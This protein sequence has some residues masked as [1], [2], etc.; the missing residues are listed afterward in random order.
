MGLESHSVRCRSRSWERIG[1]T[2]ATFALAV[3]VW[4]SFAAAARAAERF[5]SPVQIPT[6]L[7]SPS[8]VTLGDFQGTGQ[9]DIA[10][11]GSNAVS[12][13]QGEGGGAFAPP[14][15]TN[16]GNTLLGDIA[17]LPARPD[18]E[19]DYV[20]I[21][22]EENDAIDIGFLSATGFE[23]YQQLAIPCEPTEIAAGDFTGEAYGSDDFA[24]TCGGKEVVI[25]L[26]NPPTALQVARRDNNPT[27]VVSQTFVLPDPN[28][29]DGDIATTPVPD[30]GVEIIATGRAITED[31]ETGEFTDTQELDTLFPSGAPGRYELRQTPQAPG[32]AEVTT[33]LVVNGI[34]RPSFTIVGG[35]PTTTVGATVASQL[36]VIVASQFDGFPLVEYLGNGSLSADGTSLPTSRGT[37]GATALATGLF[38]GDSFTDLAVGEQLTNGSCLITIDTSG[39]TGSFTAGATPA[40]CGD[41]S[42]MQVGDLNGEG[43]DDIAYADPGDNGVFVLYQDPP[44]IIVPT[45]FHIVASLPVASDVGLLIQRRGKPRRVRVEVQAPTGAKR[46]TREVPT[47]IKVGRIPLGPHHKGR[48]TIRYKLL[49]NGHPLAPG[50]YIVTLRSLNAKGQVLD[51]SQPVALTVDRHGH[52]HFGKHV[53]V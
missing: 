45:P 32:I 5:S 41:V 44:L 4:L 33:T 53:L 38:N 19:Q 15:V 50:S 9:Q 39:A 37:E 36:N 52:A 24:V 3:A 43:L 14:V 7:D 20:A 25:V 13:V 18:S 35:S 42:D 51:L 2:V 27:W 46:V 47:F 23:L 30:S 12:W 16:L 40:A 28:L 49:V 34:P 31:F 6:G 26:A 8:A 10:A 29:M 17:R 22:D 21:V 48:N 1:A 11:V